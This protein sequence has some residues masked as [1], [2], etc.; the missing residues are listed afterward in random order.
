MSNFFNQKALP[1]SKLNNRQLTFS[2]PAP[3]ASPVLTLGITS[4][5][6]VRTIANFC[7][8]PSLSFGQVLGKLQGKVVTQFEELGW[9]SFL[10]VD[11]VTLI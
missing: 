8:L 5:G 7:S 2:K 4:K 6:Q 11:C 9:W 10:M 3:E 1:I